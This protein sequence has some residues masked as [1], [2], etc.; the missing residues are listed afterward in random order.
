MEPEGHY[1]T[2]KRPPHVPI[3]SQPNPVHTPKSHFPK[4]RLNII[5]PSTPGSPQWSPSLR[6]PHQNPVRPSDPILKKKQ[7]CNSR[8]RRLLA[9]YLLK[10]VMCTGVHSL[11][12]V[13]VQNME[14]HILTLCIF[15]S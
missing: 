3:L 6:F 4:I 13:L 15:V 7:Q 5:L 10:L 8:V 14:F 2:H 11:Q 12:A 9:V 1:R